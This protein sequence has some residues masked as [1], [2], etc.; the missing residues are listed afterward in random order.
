MDE[1]RPQEILQELGRRRIAFVVIGGVAAAAHG[2]PYP[3]RDLDIC[4]EDS[5]ENLDLLAGALVDLD[6][7]RMVAGEREPIKLALTARILRA[8]DFFNFVTRWGRLDVVWKPAATAGYPDL[9]RHAVNAKFGDVEVA[10][11]SIGDVLRSKSAL[12]RD[13][14]MKTLHVLRQLEEERIQAERQKKRD[15]R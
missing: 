1:F 7:R 2:S 11:A 15:P 5:D 6:A 3:T 4:P 10:I 9:I 12:L 14:D 8:T 13:K